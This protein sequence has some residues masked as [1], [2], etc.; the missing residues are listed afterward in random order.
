MALAL[1]AYNAGA[2]AVLRYGGIPPYRETRGY[3][4]E[5]AVASSGGFG[6]PGAAPSSAA[7]F[8]VPSDARCARRRPPSAQPAARPPQG[9]SR[10]RPRTYYRWRDERGRDPRGRGAAARGHRLLDVRA[11]D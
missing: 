8:Y 4:A 5:G 6:R 1:A 9:S 10:R 7:A 11:L 3:V 2:N